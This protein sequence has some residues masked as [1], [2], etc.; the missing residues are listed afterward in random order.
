LSAASGQFA[1]AG[2]NGHQGH[3][4]RL[5][6]ETLS[7]DTDGYSLQSGTVNLNR[8]DPSTVPGVLNPLKYAESLPTTQAINIT[9]YEGLADYDSMQ[10]VFE[11]RFNT[12][13]SVTSNYTLAFSNSTQ[14][15]MGLN[16]SG[17]IGLLPNDVMTMPLR[18][19]TCGIGWRSARPMCC[20][21]RAMRAASWPPRSRTGR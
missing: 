12:G 13:L 19:S 17:P 4:R 2:L 16:Q 7:P 3:E 20:R 6:E 10:L 8:P 1:G 18:T 14:G 15:G 21:S 11:R 9:R 5:C